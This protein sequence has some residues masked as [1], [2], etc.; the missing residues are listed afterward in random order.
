MER[1][2]ELVKE[3]RHVVV[4]EERGR[5]VDARREVANEIGDG[6][7]QHAVTVRAGALPVHPGARAFARARIEVRIEARHDLAL[8]K[9]FEVLHGRVPDA[10][11]GRPDRDPEKGFHEREK[12]RK[13]GGFREVTLH[14]RVR[15]AVAGFA[16]LFGGVGLVPALEVLKP[17]RLARKRAQFRHVALGRGLCVGGQIAQERHHFGGAFGHLRLK[18]QRAVVRKAEKLRR[19]GAQ[20]EDFRHEGRVVEL[21][22]VEFRRARRKRAVERLAQFPVFAVTHEGKV[23]GELKRHAVARATGGFGLHAIERERIGGNP[24]QARVV[25]EVERVGVRRVEQIFA[26]LLGHNRKSLADFLHAG[27]FRFG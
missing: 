12:A 3:R 26:E 4:R 18:R 20:R 8:A 24:L 11:V 10:C 15:I 23:R 14:F 21:P 22:A 25:F 2:A 17:E 16:E 27:A 1:V 9:H 5:A 19:F 7:L 6:R 13:D